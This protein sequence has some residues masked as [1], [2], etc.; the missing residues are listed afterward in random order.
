MANVPTAEA[1]RRRTTPVTAPATTGE[2]ATLRELIAQQ[3]NNYDDRVRHALDSGGLAEHGIGWDEVTPA[4]CGTGRRVAVVI[5]AYNASRTLPTVLDALATQRTTAA[6]Q[7]IVVDDAGTDDTA[8]I[9]AQHPITN[10]VFRIA[11]HGG[12]AAARNAG[13]LLAAQD[14]DLVVYLD[15]DMVLPPH[16][17]A[18]FAARFHPGLVLVG[19]RHGV[20]H[21]PGPHGWPT[22]PADEPDLT[23]DHRVRWNP[24]VGTKLFYTGLVLTEPVGGQP[25]ADTDHFRLLGHGRRYYDWDLPRMVVT[26]LVAVPYQAVLQVGGMDPSFG[27]GWGCDD[28]HLGAR[29]I[30]AGYKVVP[31]PQARGWHLDPPDAEAVWAAKFATAPGNVARYWDLLDQPFTA[32]SLAMNPDAWSLLTDGTRVK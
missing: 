25:L 15:A 30:A 14:T 11:A 23:A 8:S 6:V 7:V 21:P 18:D 4:E 19:F 27:A 5:P 24:P 3:D 9:A 28:T 16:V 12:S 20:P 10:V 31:L 1:H 22:M 2:T 17:L 32:H 13:T 29:L 26:A